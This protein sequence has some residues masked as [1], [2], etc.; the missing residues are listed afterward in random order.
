[1]NANKNN[2]KL[3]YLKLN[4]E[5]ES[6]WL[7]LIMKKIFRSKYRFSETFEELIKIILMLTLNY[8]FIKLIYQRVSYKFSRTTLFAEQDLYEMYDK[9]LR[10]NK[11]SFILF[12]A[13]ASALTTLFAVYSI[14][15]IIR[16]MDDKLVSCTGTNTQISSVRNKKGKYLNKVK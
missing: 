2:T 10:E 7:N 15:R 11:S 4:T 14:R 13:T 1:M 16:K 9:N 12:I 3:I 8:F 5:I 6:S